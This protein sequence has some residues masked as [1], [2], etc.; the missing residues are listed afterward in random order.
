M[1]I[2]SESLIND[3]IRPIKCERRGKVKQLLRTIPTFWRDDERAVDL[4]EL[5]PNGVGPFMQNRWVR[6]GGL[7]A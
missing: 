2:F 6:W 3:L 5:L 4:L 7:S 1:K